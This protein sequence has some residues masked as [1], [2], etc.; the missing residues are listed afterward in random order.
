VRSI[1]LEGKAGKYNSSQPISRFSIA[2]YRRHLY[3]TLGDGMTGKAGYSLKLGDDDIGS[4]LS[5]GLA[6]DHRQSTAP[7]GIDVRI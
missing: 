3:V 4:W 6:V 5:G 7:Q 1:G 2:S